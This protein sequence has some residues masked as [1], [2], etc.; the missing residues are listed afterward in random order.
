MWTYWIYESRPHAC[1]LQYIKEPLVK[2]EFNSSR[3]R[4]TAF[5]IQSVL[6]A[7]DIT[8][9]TYEEL[10]NK[11]KGGQIDQWTNAKWNTHYYKLMLALEELTEEAMKPFMHNAY[12]LRN[13][14]RL[15]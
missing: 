5:N 7:P 12:L 10:N 13:Y 9:K 14:I 4:E 3:D 15:I 1:Y 2:G 6:M 8:P 11:K